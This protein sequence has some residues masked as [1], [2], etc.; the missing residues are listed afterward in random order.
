MHTMK[1]HTLAPCSVYQYV[2]WARGKGV[3]LFFAFVFFS[4]RWRGPGSGHSSRPPLRPQLSVG[5][6]LS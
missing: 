2:F 1:M 5:G 3:D 6:K 4:P